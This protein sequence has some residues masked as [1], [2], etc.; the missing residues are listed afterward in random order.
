MVGILAEKPS[1][2]RNFAIALTGNDKQMQ[3]TYNGEPFVIAASHGHLYKFL[4]PEKQVSDTLS[5]K[6][7]NWNIK[8]LPWNESELQWKKGV[9]KDSSKT[10]KHIK[11]VFSSCDEI[12]IAT[13]NDPTGEGDLLAWEIIDGIGFG[14]GKKRYSRMYFP[15]E[16][17]KNVQKAFIERKPLKSKESHP[18]YLMA[19]FRSRFDYLTMQ[20]TRV[21]FAFGDGKAV[22]RQGRLKSAMV[23]LTGDGIRAYENYK[24]IPSYQNRFRDENGVSYSFKEEPIF[25][26]KEDVPNSYH[27]SK[28]IL[29]SE[30]LKHTVP[31]KL[32]DLASLSAYLSPKGF[33]ASQVL[34]VYQKLYDNKIVS[35]PRTEDKKIT[36]EQFNELLPYVDKIASVVG[37]NVSL[38]THRT[39]RKTH[40]GEGLS[41]GANRPGPNVPNSLEELKSFGSCAPIIYEF[42]AKNFLAMLCEDYE[43]L[44]QSAHLEDYPSFVGTA[45]IPKKLGFKAVFKVDEKEKEEEEPNNDK[46][47]GTIA[48]PYIHELFPPRPP[49][50]TQKWL[51]KQLE[52]Y[53]VGTGATR[54]SIFAEVTNEKDNY[55]LLLEKKGVL[56]MTLYGQ[57]SYFLL[58]D[59]YIGRIDVTET[60]HK[61]MKAVSKGE[62][63]AADCL[64]K[65]Q[66]YVLHDI[67]VMKRN[68]PEMK[69][70][71]GIKEKERVSGI[72]NG[73]EVS[74]NRIW[75]NHRFSDEE[76]SAL[77]NNET[78]TIEATSKGKTY[79]SNGKLSNLTYK[80]RNYVGYEHL[81]FGNDDTNVSEFRYNC[82]ACGEP[83][84]ESDKRIFCDCGFSMYKIMAKKTLLPKQIDEL[85]RN[86]STGM[87][88]GFKKSKPSKNK[89]QKNK[90]NARIGFSE[91]KMKVVFIFD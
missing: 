4:N 86:G 43:Y 17:E 62:L 57:M 88:Y 52:S 55:P 82:P 76:V 24:K 63:S 47:I 20:F 12:C 50:P 7:K 80:G 18:A 32:Y 87:I 14:D 1:Q 9:V 90:F 15:D 8:N 6:Y 51:M 13:D 29:D 11:D 73:K 75:G 26:K 77:L 89:Y 35:Y 23:S 30:E 5:S 58:K 81:S 33:K 68:S 72:W 28:V 10:L 39:P 59:T 64:H 56:S 79:I 16:A 60:L 85:F 19:D 67:E 22:L 74:F 49:R 37:V 36:L 3:G 41:H 44:H 45:N 25:P 38:L 53:D 46:G 42:L 91:D 66:S 2:A 84:K 54:T 69:Q 31:P 34:S 48:S 21:A 27:D 40:I 65:V 71:L 61:E 70:A 78:I 83:L